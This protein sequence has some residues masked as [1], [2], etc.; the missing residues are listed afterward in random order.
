MSEVDWY[1]GKL[2]KVERLENE[3]LENQCKRICEELNIR[4][5]H[6]QYHDNYI[7][8][9]LDEK[10]NEYIVYD[11]TLYSIS[12][13]RKDEWDDIYEASQNEDG[14]ISFNVKYYNGGCNLNEALNEALEKLK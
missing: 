1:V 8:L 11:N 12:K 6:L 2:V 4:L 3:L 7:E 9:L 14:S 5:D 13:Q 10:Y